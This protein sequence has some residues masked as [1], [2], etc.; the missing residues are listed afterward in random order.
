MEDCAPE[1]GAAEPGHQDGSRLGER[2]LS[3][4]PEPPSQ[5]GAQRGQ[6]N[7]GNDDIRLMDRNP[8]QVDQ[9]PRNCLARTG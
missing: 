9:C 5:P 8:E 1:G 7:I 3:A 4:G 6:T 2:S